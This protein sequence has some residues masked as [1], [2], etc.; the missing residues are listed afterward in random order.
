[1]SRFVGLW[2]EEEKEKEKERKSR[3]QSAEESGQRMF[4]GSGGFG[5]G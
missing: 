4:G 2:T 5:S 3:S 1:M